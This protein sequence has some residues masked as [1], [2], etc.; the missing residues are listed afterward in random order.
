MEKPGKIEIDINLNVSYVF[1]MLSVAKC[2]YN[3]SYG[4]KY[5]SFH[6]EEDLSILKKYERLITAVGGEYSGELLF[7]IMLPASADV[8]AA[9]VY[10]D[11]IK[12]FNGEI[13]EIEYLPHSKQ[14][15]SFYGKYK[16]EILDICRVMQANYLIYA[17][18]IHGEAT[19]QLIPYVSELRQKFA[20][21]DFCAKAEKE[22]GIVYPHA[23]FTVFLCESINGGPEAM[24]IS[25]NADVF[26]TGRSIEEAAFFVK[27]E[28]II[29]LFKNTFLKD[30]LEN[31]ITIEVWRYVESLAEFYLD[32][33]T[34]RHFNMFDGC[35]RLV[36]YYYGCIHEDGTLNAEQL[37]E[38]AKCEYK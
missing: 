35:E 13:Q 17:D 24:D 37:F 8:S 4:E 9:T 33:I 12:L 32:K 2:V 23:A 15:V 14:A 38:R 6:G 3:N 22:A 18:K 29:Y 34:G 28:F 1:H 20:E 16:K 31:G 26:G 19:Q 7:L 36:E 21:D 5:K 27:H 11:I 25:Y 30:Y 10:G